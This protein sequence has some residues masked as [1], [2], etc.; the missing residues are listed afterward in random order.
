MAELK[1]NVLC[2]KLNPLALD[3]LTSAY[4][5]C[6]TR[7]NPR[8]ELVHWLQMILQLQDSDVNRIVKNFELNRSHLDRDMVEALD[9]LPRGSVSKPT[10]SFHLDTIVKNAW[11]YGSLLCGENQIR[12]GHLL[13]ALIKEDEL[14]DQLLDLSPQWK[15]IKADELT[16][17]FTKIISGSPEEGLLPKDGTTLAK[18]PAGKSTPGAPAGAEKESVLESYSVDLIEKARKGEID[19]VVGRDEEVRFLISVLL[20]RRQNNPVLVGEAGVGKTAIAEGFA[21]RIVAGDVP[22]SLK[23]VSLRALDVVALQA[24]ASMKGEF[25]QRLK[26]VIE[27]VQKSAKPIILFI[28]EV[29]TLIGA[30]GSAGTGDAANL[31]KPAL[32]R[33]TLRTIAATTW[34]EYRKHIEKDP[35]LSRR[36]E[37]VLVEE[38]SEEKTILMLRR[39]VAPLEKCHKVQILDEALAAAVRLSKRFIP[40]RQ[41]PDKAVSLIDTACANVAVSQHATPARLEDARHRIDALELENQVLSRESAIG[42]NHKDRQAEVGQAL[43][44]EK[45][46]LVE[47]EIR[48]KNEKALVDKI[49]DIRARLRAA[50]EAVDAKPADGKTAPPAD[51]KGEMKPAER[52]ALLAELQSQQKQLAELQGE[53]PLLFPCVDQATIASVVAEWTGIPVGRMAR[54]GIRDVLNLADQLE[55]RVIGQRHALDMVARSLQNS[56]AKL[57]NPNRP[58][59]VFM[60]VG[61][62]G[63]GKTETA[64][65]IAEALFGTEQSL[66]TVNMGEFQEEHTV[67]TLK[68]A[69][70]GY[71]GYGEGG[72]LT[73]PVRRRPYTVVL[74]DEVE[75]AH[76]NVHRIFFQ[77]F[78]K[79]WMED[80]EGRFIDFRNSVIILT[81]NAAQD[82]IINQC[83]DPDTKPDAQG[84]EKLMREPLLKFF[85]DALLNRLVVVP[86][87][88]LSKEMLDRIIKLNL[89]RVEQRLKENH[90]VPLTYDASVLELITERCNQ[91]ER[92]ARMIEA[93]ITQTMLPDISREILLRAL[94]NRPVAKVHISAENSAFKYAYD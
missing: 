41:L 5:L 68:G 69:P 50:G 64:L 45:A 7:G 21:L 61:P 16:D 65:A 6:K 40:A 85:P 80:A 54:Q 73:E 67:S 79:G 70:P 13:L 39:S 37:K 87:Y 76:P 20:R 1:F 91:L 9:E 88:P 63:T 36:F 25:E 93:M 92:G 14:S 56:R 32:A 52:D 12:T 71:V 51:A 42:I 47:L 35:A 33:G 8:V 28:D 27:E 11:T 2:A 86:Y 53:D 22:P 24:G 58:V 57:S 94:D 48:L 34:D 78:D 55:Q 18:Q 15:K 74:L 17:N 84:L 38:P 60:F 19:P 72:I 23:D 3:A 82:V 66:L 59:G 90:Q 49:I 62:S 77:V 89:G 10:Y 30:G 26:A 46:A 43:A 81:S 4:F 31:L 75:K 83:E 44:K 29:H